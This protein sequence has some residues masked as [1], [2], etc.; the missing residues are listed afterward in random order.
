MLRVRIRHRGR[1]PAERG[2]VNKIEGGDVRN[3]N[4]AK[5]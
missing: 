2:D 5:P 3:L 1:E 4:E